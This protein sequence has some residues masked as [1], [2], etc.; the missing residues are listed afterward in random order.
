MLRWTAQLIP[1]ELMG[2]HIASGT[3]HTTGRSHDLNFRAATALFGHLGIE[4]DLRKATPTEMAELADWIAFYKQFRELLF[5]GDIVR[6]D[7]ADVSLLAGGVVAQDRSKA[8]YSFATVAT[9]VTALRG[10]LRL[11][12]LDP[13]RRYRVIPLLPGTTPSGLLPPRWWG[14]RYQA[15]DGLG[16]VAN[17]GPRAPKPVGEAT[18]IVA[19]GSVLSRVGVMEAPVN[20]D[21]VVLY[22]AEAID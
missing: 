10:R 21:H 7:S 16:D 2:S 8:I 15:I 9:P 5:T 19:P 4:W 1:P 6:I 12:G 22:L 17:G 3:S 18:G 14:V 11:P 20:P 13:S